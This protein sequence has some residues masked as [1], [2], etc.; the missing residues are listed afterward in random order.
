MIPAL[1]LAVL[2]AL[3]AAPIAQLNHG[4]GGPPQTNVVQAA[5]TPPPPGDGS[6]GPPER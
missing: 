3:L 1:V 2:L 6:G 5:V 4:S